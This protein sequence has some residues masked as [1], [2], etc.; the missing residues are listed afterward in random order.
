MICYCEIHVENGTNKVESM[1]WAI[2][3]TYGILRANIIMSC[4]SMYVHQCVRAI[5]V[6]SVSTQN[7]VRALNAYACMCVCYGYVFV[8]FS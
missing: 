7:V 3:D 1:E 4:S 6:M 2:D 8:W 5:A